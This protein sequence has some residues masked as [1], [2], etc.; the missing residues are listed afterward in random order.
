MSKHLS[1]P[2][3]MGFT[4]SEEV[5]EARAGRRPNT[6][7]LS[8]G[9]KCNLNC[10]YC[11][12]VPKRLRPERPALSDNEQEKLL[13]DAASL[14]VRYLVIPG[15]GEPLLYS[16]LDRLVSAAIGHDMYITIIT[17]GTCID[18]KRALHYKD[19]PVS[20]MVKLNSLDKGVQDAL[21]GRSGMAEKIYR[22]IDVLIEVGFTG[23]PETRLAIDALICKQTINEIPDIIRFA[24]ERQIHP[25]VERLLVMGR[26]LTNRASL[27][28]DESAAEQVLQDVQQIMGEREGNA[29]SGHVCDLHDYTLFVDVDGMVTK[30]VGGQREILI[31]DCRAD[32]LNDIWIRQLDILEEDAIANQSGVSCHKCP[33]RSYC[34]TKY[35][36][37]PEHIDIIGEK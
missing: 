19:L 34:E 10:T 33:G 17:N 3:M 12:T 9:E 36:L 31:G 29:F 8:V 14:G 26:G 23:Y 27:E 5:L 11:Y 2:R 15:P 7:F 32:S 4:T 13:E 37:A 28:V 18:K 21:V 16:G 24:L 30:C 1:I 35:N 25:V 22:A 6:L 20:F